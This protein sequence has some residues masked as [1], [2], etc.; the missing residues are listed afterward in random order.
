MI[1]TKGPEGKRDCVVTR[2]FKYEGKIL[3]KGEKVSLKAAFAFE[4]K[5][6][7]KVKYANE[8]VDLADDK[9]KKAEK[10]A[11]KPE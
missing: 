1:T 7:N 3:E 9:P 10:K 6:A 4:M 8:A 11:E 2:P 5:S